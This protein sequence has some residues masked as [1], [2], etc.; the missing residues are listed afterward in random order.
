MAGG[1][2]DVDTNADVAR[3]VGALVADPATRLIFMPVALYDFTASV[4]EG[5]EPTA[6]G[7]RAPRLR[8]DDG[9]QTLALTPTPK[10]IGAI[11][12][13][14]K[15]IFLVGFKT[16]AGAA[17]DAQF[18]AGL[19]LLKQSSCNRCVRPPSIRSARRLR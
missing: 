5:G 11:R 16:T 14:R 13:E 2:R 8:S 12:R 3:L 17:P 10:V 4:L 19:R 7:K 9:T 1:P 18:A 6:S 15:D